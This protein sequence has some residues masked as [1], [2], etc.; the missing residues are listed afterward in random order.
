M[1]RRRCTYVLAQVW[2]T[3]C[4]LRHQGASMPI[5]R[6]RSLPRN[7]TC[8]K[9]WVHLHQKQAAPAPMIGT[10]A[11]VRDKRVNLTAP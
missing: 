7:H 2:K 9:A 1:S 10:N 6:R 8:A 3:V 4:D 5:S 11:A